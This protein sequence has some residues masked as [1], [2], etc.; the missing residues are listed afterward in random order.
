MQNSLNGK[1]FNDA[2]DVKS[3]LIQFFTGRNQKFYEYGITTLLER[4][5][6]V[7]DKCWQY[8]ID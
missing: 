5:K 3:H 4:C 1:I 7:M 6:K 2:D 8:L